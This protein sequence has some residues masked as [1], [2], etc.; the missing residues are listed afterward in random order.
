MNKTLLIATRNKDKIREISQKLENLGLEIKSLNDFPQIPGI[1]EDGI[2]IEDNAIKKAQTG[3]K[4]TGLLTLADDTGLEVATLKGAPGV[5][6]SRYAG[7]GATYADNRRKLLQAMQN[8]PKEKRNAVFRTV[9]AICDEN[10][11]I[12][13]EGKC[14][15]VIIEEER[16]SAGFG[17]DP[18]F[19]I[20]ELGK[21]FAEMTLEQ[22]NRISHRGKAFA[23]AR[24]I[25]ERKIANSE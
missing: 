18:V 5:Y 11:V 17:Y 3:F 25:I 7:K 23:K 8:I 10:G 13:V 16:G 1:N 24:E 15:G 21:T 12:L 6:S 14:E 22:K 9:A 20:P 2:T 19:M 4:A